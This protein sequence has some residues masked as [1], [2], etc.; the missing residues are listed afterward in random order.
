MA[1]IHLPLVGVT[2][3]SIV[4]VGS[5]FI[6]IEL[7]F[8]HTIAVRHV[9]ERYRCILRLVGMVE[10]HPMPLIRLMARS[11]GFHHMVAMIDD[12]R[13]MNGMQA[14]IVSLIINHLCLGN[15]LT[16]LQSEGIASF[17]SIEPFFRFSDYCDH[18]RTHIIITTGIVRPKTNPIAIVAHLHGHGRVNLGVCAVLSRCHL[19]LRYT[20]VL[21][22]IVPNHIRF[23]QFK[24]LPLTHLQRRK[25]H[26]NY[27]HIVDVEGNHIAEHLVTRIDYGKA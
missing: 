23:G 10:R 19:P 12:N 2:G 18:H 17:N 21:I 9:G 15:H 22:H 13:L 7:Q 24:T 16:R 11:N 26:S 1:R 4:R 27:R 8:H 14:W 3:D 20:I 25:L 6:E 5:K